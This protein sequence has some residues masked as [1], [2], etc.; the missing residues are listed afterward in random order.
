M[1]DKI[2][3]RSAGSTVSIK[4][5]VRLTPVFDHRLAVSNAR[6]AGGNT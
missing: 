6:C 5:T 4:P 3:A 2:R 1:C